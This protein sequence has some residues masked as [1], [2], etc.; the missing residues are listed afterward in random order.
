MNEMLVIVKVEETVYMIRNVIV[1]FIESEDWKDKN[2][3]AF[4]IMNVEWVHKNTVLRRL[5]I[6][7]SARMAANCLLKYG[8]SF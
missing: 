1:P 6:S 7:E 4:E 2:I 3:H 8:I 5:K